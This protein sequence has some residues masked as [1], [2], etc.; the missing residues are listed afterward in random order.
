MWEVID[1]TISVVADMFTI[2]ASGIAIFLFFF[3]RNDIGAFFRA[4][5]NFTNQTSLA[6]VRQKLEELSSLNAADVT[7]AAEVASIFHDICGR[8]D[9]NPQLNARFS[10]FA[11][12]VRRATGNT[13][14]PIS[15]PQKRALVSELRECLRH[16]D[17][18][19]YS[20]A[21]GDFKK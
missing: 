7:Q 2:G 16:L 9:G 13:K 21:M 5:V 3:K 10:D 15:E 8:I 14:R 18:V 11:I 19:N 6:E 17:A 12:R 1:K 20:E 4:V